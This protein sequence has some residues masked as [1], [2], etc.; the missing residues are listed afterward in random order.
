MTNVRWYSIAT[1][2]LVASGVALIGTHFDVMNPW[3]YIGMM[4]VIC[5]GVSASCGV[6]VKHARSMDDEFEA[7]YRIG[8]KA[9]RRVPQ[10]RP[11]NSRRKAKEVQR[12]RVQEVALRSVAGD[13][14]PA[15]W[16]ASDAH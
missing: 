3:F 2:A 7:G 15:R 9:G 10:L 8:Y 13:H 1:L 12:G 4:L 16:S 6:H 5:S 14:S 11:V